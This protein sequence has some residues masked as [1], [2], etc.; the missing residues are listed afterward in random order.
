MMDYWKGFMD[1]PL[2]PDW[3][4]EFC[5]EQAGLTWG[6]PHGMCRCN[7]CH[8]VYRMYD[9][10][11]KRTAVPQDAMKSEYS[12]AFRLIWAELQI[13]ASDVSDK[14]WDE[15]IAKTRKEE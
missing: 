9:E 5:G 15:Y 12:A 11:G 10:D 8:A 7:N 3:A 14:V 1:W 4:C 2:A 13:P 6:M